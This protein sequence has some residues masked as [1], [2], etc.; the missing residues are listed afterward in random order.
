DWISRILKSE[1]FESGQLDFIFCTDP[2]LLE[3]NLQY[4]GHDTLTDVVSFDYSA[5]K[6][7]SGD[8]FISTER[9]MDNAKTFEVEFNNE[10]LRVMAH[11]VLH[12]MGYGDKA[13]DQT[14]V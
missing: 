1:G 7:I 12:L 13:E 14:V 5:G 10:L 8:I 3:I 9:V 11:G 6:T 4:L 2:A